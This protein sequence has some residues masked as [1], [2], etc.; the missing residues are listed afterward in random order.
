MITGGLRARLI[1]DSFEAMVE[2]ALRARGWFDAGRRHEPVTIMSAP[3]DWN[4]PVT[5][6][7]IAISASDVN[8]ESA[9]M[10]SN[11]T[12]DTWTYYVDI[13]AESESLGMDVAHDVR[14]ILRGKLP[15]VGRGLQSFDVYDYTLATPVVIFQ[16]EIENVIVDRARGTLQPWERFW[17]PVRC[18]VVDCYGN[19]DDDA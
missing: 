6:N 19:E 9:E 5:V 2:A 16:C 18:E 4:E 1:R 17:F 13:Y 7:A 8:D 15:S 12:Q 10:G 14:D 3:A 11:Y